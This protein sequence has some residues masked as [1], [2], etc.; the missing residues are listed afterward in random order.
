M[1]KNVI[2]NTRHL[3]FRTISSYFFGQPCRGV[4]MNRNWNFHWGEI[5]ASDDPCHETYAG[6]RPFSEPETRAIS[7]FIMDRKDRIK[8]YLTMH[9]YSQMWLVPWGYTSKRAGD[10][11]D[12]MSMG[13]K[14]VEAL[15]RVSGTQY[16]VG[17]A[18]SLLY[19]TSGEKHS[20]A[21]H[22]PLLFI[23]VFLNNIVETGGGATK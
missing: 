16:K 21:D 23:R 22:T 9:A 5:G 18:T 2:K 14:A 13:R 3:F 11:E 15:H 1:S 19:P 4:D 12:L 10:Y 6:P 17:P 8:L 20:C 7:D